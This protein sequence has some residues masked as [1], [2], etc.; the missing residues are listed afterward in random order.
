M[1]VTHHTFSIER[2]Y[3]ASPKRVFAAWSTAEEK[4]KW[5]HGNE[6]RSRDPLQLDFR[7]GGRERASG[8]TK[9][10]TRTTYEALYLNIVPDERI[11]LTY[12][13]DLDGRAISTSLQTV[14]LA[15]D[16]A[17]TRLTFTEQDAFLDGFDG[18]AS[19]EEGTRILL[20]QIAEA[21]GE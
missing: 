1:S 19:R 4:A 21:L 17:G 13:M 2:R 16:G 8:V 6:E 9:R 18:A 20:E 3:K 12:W 5:F 15:P 11:I 10:G 7:V 14:E